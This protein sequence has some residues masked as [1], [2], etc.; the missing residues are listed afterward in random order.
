MK[1][2]T[3]LR[4]VAI[5]GEEED[6]SAAPNVEVQPNDAITR[7]VPNPVAESEVSPATPPPALLT[8]APPRPIQPIP[9]PPRS[10]Q[11]IPTPPRPPT[12]VVLAPPRPIQAMP[13]PPSVPTI[14][15]ATAVFVTTSSPA[16]APATSPEKAKPSLKLAVL[17][18]LA[19][20]GV[21]VIVFAFVLRK[22]APATP[23]IPVAAAPRTGLTAPPPVAASAASA[24]TTATAKPVEETI[25]L[26]VVATPI[27]AT[28]SLD[29]NVVAGHTLNLKVPRDRGIHII[30]ASAPGY[31]P[32][33]QQVGFDGDVVLTMN[34]RRGHATASR[35]SSR[36]RSTVV[37][38]KTRFEAPRPPTMPTA[39]ASPGFEPGMNLEAP[40]ARPNAKAIDERNPYKP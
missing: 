20:A 34:L 16:P 26:Q 21:A 15:A 3:P 31:I 40:A 1:N 38:P 7:K 8:V 35:A 32:F 27:E 19:M 28:L 17:A 33:N 37:E 36:S 13:V 6:D 23:T 30:S 9:V 22:P 4:L 39:K 2:K 12:K 14:N 24:P 29:G 18:G 5:D 10:T 25:H 11:I